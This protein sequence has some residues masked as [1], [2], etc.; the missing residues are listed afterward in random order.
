MFHRGHQQHQNVGPNI[1]HRYRR[2]ASSSSS[3]SKPQPSTQR[4]KQRRQRQ[5]ISEDQDIPKWPAVATVLIL[6]V[7][8]AAWGASEW[9]FGNQEKKMN[10]KLRTLF[11]NN[12]ELTNTAEKHVVSSSSSLESK[13]ILFYCVIRRNTGFNHCMTG[14]QVGDVVEVLEEGVG[15][16][17][18]VTVTCCIL[19]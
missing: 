8:F 3:T 13:P 14:I 17:K 1:Q 6:P 12:M 19:L 9:I 5:V 10:E 4:I 16:G 15:P 11:L 18:I 7:M 2:T